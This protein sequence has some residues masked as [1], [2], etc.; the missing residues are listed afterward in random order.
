MFPNLR[1][2][3]A[4]AAAAALV[5]RVLP[6]LIASLAIGLVLAA[7]G[8]AAGAKSDA[9]S[10]GAVA[11][12]PRL[13]DRIQRDGT[14]AVIVELRLPGPGFAPEGRLPGRAEVALQRREIAA[15]GDQVLGLLL[16]TN[17]RV[18]R[19]FQTV[20]FLALEIGPDA[21]AR[22]QSAGPIV[23]RVVED[24]VAKASLAESVPRIG[25]DQLW[26][27]G[28]D[29]SG[30]MIA[31]LDTGVD[32]THPFLANKVVEEA[33]YSSTVAGAAPRFVPMVRKSS[34]VPEQGSTARFPAASTALM[35]PASQPET[36]R[37]RGRPSPAS[38]EVP[39]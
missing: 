8:A 19:R 33:C 7:S 39:T 5:C 16:G 21:L 32:S 13:A 38:P 11:V 6:A 2:S 3:T 4:A 15:R 24:V 18:H 26:A 31:V 36:A 29:G 34:S 20:P 9:D 37:P 27:Q 10:V 25:A 12:A 14:A 23:A 1:R 17:H 30:T 35:S 22:L 28:F